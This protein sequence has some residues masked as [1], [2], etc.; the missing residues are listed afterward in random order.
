MAPKGK[1]AEKGKG[2]GKDTSD[3]KGSGKEQKGAQVALIVKLSTDRETKS[4]FL[5]HQRTTHLVRKARK[6]R[7]SSGKVER[8]LEVR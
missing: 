7:R 6:E 5:E 1:A 2:K 4:E 3:N 8:R